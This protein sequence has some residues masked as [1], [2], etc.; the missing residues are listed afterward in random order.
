MTKKKTT[1]T[2]VSATLDDFLTAE[3]HSRS[4][5][6]SWFRTTPGVWD[7]CV[8]FARAYDSGTT[9]RSISE[10]IRLYLRPV[11]GYKGTAKHVYAVIATITSEE[12]PRGEEESPT[13]SSK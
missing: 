9:S 4:G 10:F 8:K 3:P 7:A 1:A 2:T 6:S 11:F 12:I 13:R 5:H